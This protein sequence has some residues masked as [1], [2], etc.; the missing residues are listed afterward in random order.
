MGFFDE[1]QSLNYEQLIIL[2]L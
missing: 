1:G 2:R